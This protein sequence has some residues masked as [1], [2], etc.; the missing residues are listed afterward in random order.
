M[1]IILGN[2]PI[3]TEDVIIRSTDKAVITTDTPVSFQID[4]EYC[5][6]QTRLDIAILP[7]QMKIAIPK[8]T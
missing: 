4:G 2:I 7:K 1:K 6:E 5:G 8:I 3:D